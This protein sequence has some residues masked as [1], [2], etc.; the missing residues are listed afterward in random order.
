[1]VTWDSAPVSHSLRQRCRQALGSFFCAFQ[2]DDPWWVSLLHP[3]KNN[4]STCLTYVLGLKHSVG[5]EFLCSAGLLKVGHS[6][7][8]NATVVVTSE[9]EKFIVEE[10]LTDLVESVN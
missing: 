5:I 6:R 10:Q 1:M 9:W 8:P 3:V 7:N 4:A 2:K